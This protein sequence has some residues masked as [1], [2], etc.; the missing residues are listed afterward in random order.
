MAVAASA[1]LS[2]CRYDVPSGRPLGGSDGLLAVHI[3]MDRF[4]RAAVAMVARIFVP[5]LQGLRDVAALD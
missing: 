3:G 5:R 2:N 1:A 4:H